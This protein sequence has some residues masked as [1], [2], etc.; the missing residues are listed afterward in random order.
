MKK[1][2]TALDTSSPSLGQYG[3]RARQSW[4]PV[5]PSPSRTQD[6][7]RG[8]GCTWRNCLCPARPLLELDKMLWA[9]EKAI[10]DLSAT[11][12][13][14]LMYKMGFSFLHRE[15]HKSSRLFIL[16]N[17]LNAGLWG[18]LCKP[19]ILKHN[20]TGKWAMERCM[21]N[22]LHLQSSIQVAGLA[23]V[24]IRYHGR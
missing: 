1:N 7:R 17:K 22:V 15:K 4:G 16:L 9:P 3:Q 13:S 18:I 8:G 6:L 21:V 19:L 12:C 10:T 5:A 24:S 2:D 20:P 23:P 14:I 11:L